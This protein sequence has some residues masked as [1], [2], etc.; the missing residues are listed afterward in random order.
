M[1]AADS[2][3]MDLKQSE[4]LYNYYRLGSET[5]SNSKAISVTGCGG[6]Q[7]Y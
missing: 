4:K 1:S 5:K 7:G 2:Q 3:S 6:V